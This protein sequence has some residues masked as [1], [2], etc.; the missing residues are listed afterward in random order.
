VTDALIQYKA[1]LG[2]PNAL[3]RLIVLFKAICR[4]VG[5]EPNVFK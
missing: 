1:A 4:D 2:T 5:I 3:D